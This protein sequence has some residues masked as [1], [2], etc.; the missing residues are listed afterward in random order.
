MALDGFNG[1]SATDGQTNER[2]PI[3]CRLYSNSRKQ[4]IYFIA[5]LWVLKRRLEDN[6]EPKATEAIFRE[7]LHI[8]DTIFQGMHNKIIHANH[9][10]FLYT[11]CPRNIYSIYSS[12]LDLVLILSHPLQLPVVVTMSE[13]ARGVRVTDPRGD[14]RST[15]PPLKFVA[16]PVIAVPFRC[17]FSELEPAISQ[18]GSTFRVVEGMRVRVAA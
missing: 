17:I 9:T 10:A 14:P 13:L 15:R 12:I 11:L 18:A 3:R 6:P 16:T 4:H 2:L 8:A 1:S 7:N 5:D